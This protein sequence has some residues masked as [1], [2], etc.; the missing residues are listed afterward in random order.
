MFPDTE[1]VQSGDLTHYYECVKSGTGFKR[2]H[3]Q[4]EQGTIFDGHKCTL[5]M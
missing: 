5:K 2:F 4:C 1:K 3:R